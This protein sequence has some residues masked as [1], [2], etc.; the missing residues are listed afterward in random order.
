MSED[1]PGV[2]NGGDPRDGGDS[3]GTRDGD[4]V[5]P[6][7]RATLDSLLSTVEGVEDDGDPETALSALDTAATVA[8]NKV[9]DPDERE[10]LVHGC[11]EARAALSGDDA[12]LAAAYA[13][14]LRARLS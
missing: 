9:P 4:G 3:D 1:D 11:R 10:R 2:G 6:D 13:R 5:P 7:V 12:A 8:R 14:L